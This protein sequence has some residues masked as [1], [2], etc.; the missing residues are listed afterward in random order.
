MFTIYTNA[1]GNDNPTIIQSNVSTSMSSFQQND[2]KENFFFSF[3]RKMKRKYYFTENEGQDK[4]ENF[5]VI[6]KIFV[7]D[8]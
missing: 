7:Y 6:N 8:P 3:S 1:G 2:N 4:E 5:T